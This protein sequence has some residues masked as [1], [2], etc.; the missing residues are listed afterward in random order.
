MV[1]AQLA[2]N[3][4]QVNLSQGWESLKT[5]IIAK[6]KKCESI[7]MSFMQWVD[8]HGKLSKFSSE[9]PWENEEDSPETTLE[10]LIAELNK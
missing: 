8:L 6:D 4:L 7:G 10:N 3:E 2:L 1:E 5:E 9:F